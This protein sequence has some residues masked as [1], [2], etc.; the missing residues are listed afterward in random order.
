MQKGKKDRLYAENNMILIRSRRICTS[1]RANANIA[2]TAFLSIYSRYLGM[3]WQTSRPA[4]EVWDVEGRRKKLF[5]GQNLSQWG[6]ALLHEKA[7][8]T[9]YNGA[10]ID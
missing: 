9:A 10:T 6:W 5:V 1:W 8:K 2:Y 4:I 3:L 7:L